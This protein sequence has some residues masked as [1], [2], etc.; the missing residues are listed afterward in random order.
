MAPP[1]RIRVQ[2]VPLG[3]GGLTA[4]VA[5]DADPERRRRSLEGIEERVRALHGEVAVTTAPEG[6]EVKVTLPPH[7]T[8]R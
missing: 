4:T 6:T 5:D 8:R 7:A 2:L 1:G 3:D